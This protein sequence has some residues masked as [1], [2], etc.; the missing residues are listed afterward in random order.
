MWLMAEWFKW[1]CANL[2]PILPS[3]AFSKNANNGV[4]GLK[5]RLKES[6]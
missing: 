5:V 3:Q 4:Q 6:Y 1:G 2:E